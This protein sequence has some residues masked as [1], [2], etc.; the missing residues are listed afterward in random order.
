MNKKSLTLALA[1]A[2]LTSMTLLNCSK[3]EDPTPAST[4]GTTTSRTTILL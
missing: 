1:T 4:S 3:K 2:L